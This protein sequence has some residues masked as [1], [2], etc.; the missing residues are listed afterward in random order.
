M[1]L[2]G[3]YMVLH[4]PFVRQLIVAY[5]SIWIRCHFWPGQNMI[6]SSRYERKQLDQ[7]N[8]PSSNEFCISQWMPNIY[9]QNVNNVVIMSVLKIICF[10]QHFY[11]YRRYSSACMRWRAADI[12]IYSNLT[13]CS[14]HPKF[15]LNFTWSLMR[16]I[17]N[18]NVCTFKFES[19]M[20]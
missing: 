16:K 10:H 8:L 4:P 14:I 1:T 15:S 2:I 20:E 5:P 19:G 3:S 6:G 9:Q 13:L 17:I 7:Q 12:N 18:F 11:V